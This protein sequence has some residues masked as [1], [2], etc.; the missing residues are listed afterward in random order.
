[1][2]SF[3]EGKAALAAG[4]AIHYVGAGGAVNFNQWHNNNTPFG[5]AGYTASGGPRTVG[6]VSS[7][8]L[9]KLTG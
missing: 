2:H 6:I 5:A 1:V 9:A 8:A 4:K 3:A 7:S